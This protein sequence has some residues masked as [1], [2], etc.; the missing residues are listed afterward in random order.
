MRDLYSNDVETA[1]ALAAW[2]ELPAERD[3]PSPHELALGELPV[4]AEDFRQAPCASAPPPA[5]ED[6]P[7]F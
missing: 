5:E 6:P 3:E 2:D 7:P 1:A 4:M